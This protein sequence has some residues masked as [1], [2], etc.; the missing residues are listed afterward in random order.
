MRPV[1][2][3]IISAAVVCL[4]FPVR[5]HCAA[6]GA[7]A[8]AFPG[9]AAGG[10]LTVHVIDV[11]HGDAVLIQTPDGK[12]ILIDSGAGEAVWSEGDMG[13]L[14]VVP[15]LRELGVHVID[16]LIISHAHYDHIGGMATVIKRLGVREVVDSGYPRT[17]QVYQDLLELIREKGI[18]YR[19]VRKGDIL[20]FGAGVEARVL[21]PSR[22]EYR[23]GKRAEI[24]NYS[25][26]IRMEYGEVS[27][28]FTGDL[29]KEGER[30]V[31]RAGYPVRS[32][33]LKVGHHGSKTSSTGS[34]VSA[35]RP[36]VALVSCGE[37]PKFTREKPCRNLRRVGARIYRTD[38]RGTLVVRTDGKSYS[39]E[40]EREG[41]Y[42]PAGAASW[43]MALLWERAA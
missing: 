3:L 8:A 29:E 12:N 28:L 36:E 37:R 2:Y 7:P 38:L 33:I 23:W 22:T 17:T 41:G 15:Y 11:G 19:K 9:T 35:V 30:D 20:S 4:V 27:F 21:H 34:F 43:G 26:V 14:A 24:N 5:I 32:T 1:R 10:E 16:M 25:I 13:E 6:P 39:V 31:L 18:P 40:T 42:F